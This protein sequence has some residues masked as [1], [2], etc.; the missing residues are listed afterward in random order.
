MHAKSKTAAGRLMALLT[1]GALVLMGTVTLSSSASAED[2]E[3]TS[4]DV[5]GTIEAQP[6]PGYGLGDQHPD[7]AAAQH[8]LVHL[9]HD[10]YLDEDAPSEFDGRTEAS[11]Q[12]FQAAHGLHED[13]RLNEETWEALRRQTF[14]EFGT[15]SNGEVV[16]AVQFLLNAKFYSHLTVDGRYGPTTEGALTDAQDHFDIAS[17]GIVG[18]VTWRAL[19]TYDDY[20]R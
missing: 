16:E 18:K 10:P 11:V 7:I 14:G 15:G 20:D 5:V 19:V 17:D 1:V 2:L 4:D 13:G 6:W 8:L 9:G 12:A 3:A